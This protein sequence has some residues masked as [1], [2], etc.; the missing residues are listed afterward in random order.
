[1][2]RSGGIYLVWIIPRLKP[3]AHNL[4]RSWGMWPCRIDEPTAQEKNIQSKKKDLS[5]QRRK[6]KGD[7]G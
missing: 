6:R 2:Q 1:M 7:N 5:R 3:Y 4:L